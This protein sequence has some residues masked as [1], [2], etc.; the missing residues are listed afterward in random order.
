MSREVLRDAFIYLPSKVVPAAV[1]LLSIPI[2]TRFLSPESYGKYSLVLTTLLLVSSFCISWLP[3]VVLRFNIIYG[4]KSLH[5]YLFSK[6]L[7]CLI[8]GFGIWFLLAWILAFPILDPLLLISG[9]VWLIG[10]SYFEYYLG[11]LR[12]RRLAAKYSIAVCWRSIIGIALVFGI[13]TLGYTSGGAVILMLAASMLIGLIF[14]HKL[15]IGDKKSS[16][17]H[18]QKA[19][20]KTQILK[21]GIPAAFLNLVVLSLSL[22]DRYFIHVFLGPESVAIYGASYDI[23]EKT[24]FFVNS[25]LLFSSSIIGIRIFENEGEVKASEFLFK[26]MRVYIIVGPFL[27]FMLIILS[28]VIFN[29]ILPADYRSGIDVLPI[30]AVSGLFVGIMHR[31]SLLLSFHKRTDLNLLCGIGALFVNLILCWLL[32]PRYGTVGAAVGTFVSYGSWL[33]FVRLSTIKFHCPVFP[34]KTLFSVVIA[35][36]ISFAARSFISMYHQ[37]LDIYYLIANVS[38]VLI[39]YSLVLFLLKEIKYSDFFPIIEKSQKGL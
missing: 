13:L 17:G 20:D 28:P 36:V 31:Y 1:G 10:Q 15:A 30:I 24:I 3:S 27:I 38:V 33:T 16:D 5:K 29:Y 22:V 11:W 18:P 32:I 9:I 39:I 2:L 34:W 7:A 21:Y 26:I 12:A 35:L 37:A 8:S 19:I 14:L 6:F 4:V 23:A 25:M